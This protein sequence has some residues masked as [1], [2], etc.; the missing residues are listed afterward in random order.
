MSSGRRF[1]L[2]E[3]VAEG[4]VDVLDILAA[5]HGPMLEPLSVLSGGSKLD[6]LAAS[7]SS[8][9]TPASLVEDIDN[10]SL[11]WSALL[12]AVRD[13]K[14]ALTDENR[15]ELLDVARRE[16]Q[17]QGLR[18]TGAGDLDDLAPDFASALPSYVFGLVG[19]LFAACE[20][21]MAKNKRSSGALR[22]MVLVLLK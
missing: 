1:L 12:K 15:D 7:I 8:G 4:I 5:S 11:I 17:Y 13:C 22:Q 9:A 6:S 20:I 18:V 2:T 19:S 14:P 3:D 21:L 10:D 16:V